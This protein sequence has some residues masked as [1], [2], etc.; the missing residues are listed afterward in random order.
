MNGTVTS[1]SLIFGLKVQCTIWGLNVVTAAFCSTALSDCVI[2]T[3]AS[4]NGTP[5]A[6]V[7]QGVLPGYLKPRRAVVV[8]F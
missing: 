3:L 8:H 2:C 5:L 7:P 4:A 6:E 1:V